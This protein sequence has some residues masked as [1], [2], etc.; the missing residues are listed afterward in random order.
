[1]NMASYLQ[2]A[3][4]AAV[5]EAHAAAKSAFVQHRLRWMRVK[6]GRNDWELQ[7]Q[8]QRGDQKRRPEQAE[9]APTQPSQNCES[10]VG[11]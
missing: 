6:S 10:R 1:L 5:P 7:Q 8:A 2:P 3:V 11:L 4:E 9:S